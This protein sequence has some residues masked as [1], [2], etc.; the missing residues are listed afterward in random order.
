MKKRD[1]FSSK[2][3]LTGVLI[4]KELISDQGSTPPKPPDPEKS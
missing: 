3:H 4:L 2:P 1:H